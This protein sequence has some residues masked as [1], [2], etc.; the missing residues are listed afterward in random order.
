MRC[1]AGAVMDE[2]NPLR[3][4]FRAEHRA[5]TDGFTYSTAQIK[6]AGDRGVA[7]ELLLRDALARHLPGQFAVGRGQVLDHTGWLSRQ[8]DLVVFDAGRTPRMFA[9]EATQTYPRESILGLIQVKSVLT[10]QEIP[11]TVRQITEV[12]ERPLAIAEHPLDKFGP[13]VTQRA[14]EY[15]QSAIFAYGKRGKI[16]SLIRSFHTEN[17]KHDPNVRV[18]SLCILSEGFFHYTGRGPAERL[19]LFRTYNPEDTFGLF[20]AAMLDGFQLG[21]KIQQV[22]ELMQYMLFEV[23]AS[24][25]NT[26]LTSATL[27]RRTVG[28][29][30]IKVASTTARSA[31]S[32]RPQKAPHTGGVV[33]GGTERQR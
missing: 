8:Q 13:T 24:A 15:I 32:G 7:R 18:R 1:R 21:V 2:H 9:S 14:R 11:E 20:F 6:H 25:A 29:N 30:T 28:A 10:L 23:D 19:T 12:A 16:E 4:F 27:R 5:L 17:L 22:P 3:E 26:D 33:Q 31:T